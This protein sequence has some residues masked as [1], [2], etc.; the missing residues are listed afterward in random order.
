[1][2]TF[3][4]II[5]ASRSTDNDETYATAGEVEGELPGNELGRITILEVRQNAFALI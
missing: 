3:L 2:L 4:D 5:L 1:V